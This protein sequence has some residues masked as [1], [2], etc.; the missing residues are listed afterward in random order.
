MKTLKMKNMYLALIAMVGFG[1]IS[2]ENMNEPL[3]Y[4][5]DDTAVGGIEAI[6][7]SSIELDDLE[8][9]GGTLEE[10]FEIEEI[11]AYEE[12]DDN[13]PEHQDKFGR[14]GRKGFKR[15]MRGVHLKGIFSD[16]ALTDE[17]KEQNKLLVE[18]LKVCS[19]EYFEAL[20]TATRAIVEP[21]NEQ[22]TGI[23]E[24]VRSGDLTKEEAKEQLDALR[25]EIKA[26][27]EASE[28]VAALKESIKACR[29]TYKT[30]FTALLTAEQ[31]EIWNAFLAEKEAELS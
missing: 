5:E 23:K 31:L 21:Y 26:E 12:C 27:L 28:E 25:E 20:R 19:S 4:D 11:E 2:C 9:E 10:A 30:A 24:L 14:K 3:P 17:Q 18:D 29:E 15:K 7:T 22:R 13:R 6:I 8:I 1:L 16:L